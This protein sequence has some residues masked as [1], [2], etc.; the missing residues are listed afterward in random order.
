MNGIMQLSIDS[1]KNLVFFLFSFLLCMLLKIYTTHLLN[2]ENK[3]RK[4]DIKIVICEL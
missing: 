3:K 2:I 1:V 4:I